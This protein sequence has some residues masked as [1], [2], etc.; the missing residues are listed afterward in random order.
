MFF[1][2]KGLSYIMSDDAIVFKFIYKLLIL[3]A[4]VSRTLSSQER[5]I[6]FT[7]C[8]F[9]V[10]GDGDRQLTSCLFCWAVGYITTGM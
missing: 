6:L 8:S 3:T 2:Q 10:G 1:L 7:S 9:S 5:S 4:D